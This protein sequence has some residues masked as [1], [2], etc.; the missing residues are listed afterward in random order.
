[1]A[2]CGD[3]LGTQAVLRDHLSPVAQFT[4]RPLTPADA[5]SYRAFRLDALA[6][7]PDAFISSADEEARSTAQ[8]LQKRL[9]PSHTNVMLG[10]FAGRELVGS[11]G[12][13]R[14]PR[15]KERHKA[16]LYGM[17]VREAHW[18]TGI[19]RA[20]LDAVIAHGRTWAGLEQIV[21]TVTASNS[22]ARGLYLGA[23]FVPFGLE[24]R[25]LKVDGHYH[26]KEHLILLL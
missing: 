22:A 19:G 20:L 21:L 13:E 5:E 12:L 6:A 7:F 16:L 11:A 2:R 4:L 9:A 1:M 25:A 8:W 24:P 15:A 10:A 3:G 23:G 14:K 17:V 18:G 26:D